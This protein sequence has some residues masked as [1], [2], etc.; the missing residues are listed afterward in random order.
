MKDSNGLDLWN[1]SCLSCLGQFCSPH[2]Y[3]RAPPLNSE[4]PAGNED[5]VLFI[6]HLV[7]SEVCQGIVLYVEEGSSVC[8][9]LFHSWCSQTNVDQPKMPNHTWIRIMLP[10]GWFRMKIGTIPEAWYVC[11]V[12]M[13]TMGCVLSIQG[14]K[15]RHGQHGELYKSNLHIECPKHDTIWN[16]PK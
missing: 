13:G 3:W 8:V 1:C 14:A 9:T 15:L 4:N 16:I 5:W 7:T 12:N 10:F 2:H 11:S 6:Q